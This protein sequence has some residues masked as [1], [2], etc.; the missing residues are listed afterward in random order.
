MDSNKSYRDVVLS[1]L[2][3]TPQGETSKTDT[4]RKT[5]TLRFKGRPQR[6]TIQGLPFDVIFLIFRVA[7]VSQATCLGL[8][9]RVLY[10]H[11]KT[12]HPS[13]IPLKSFSCS[14]SCSYDCEWGD[15]GR[16]WDTL[17]DRLSDSSI[18]KGYRP[19]YFLNPAEENLQ[20]RLQDWYR[21]KFVGKW[22]CHSLSY[23]SYLPSP[24]NLGSEWDK[25][26]L[27]AIKDDFKHPRHNHGRDWKSYWQSFEI[28]KENQAAFEVIMDEASWELCLTR[29][30]SEM[31]VNPE[32][33]LPTS[34]INY[35]PQGAGAMDAEIS[36]YVTPPLIKANSGDHMRDQ[37]RY[38]C[39]DQSSMNVSEAGGQVATTGYAPALPKDESPHAAKGIFAKA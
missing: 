27:D 7:G 6:G 14:G 1:N 24:Y 23:E 31:L 13:P 32:E 8:T 17:A 9:C 4:K 10:R 21:A 38:T 37:D 2:R 35:H 15:Y 20:I 36:K 39:E 34:Q 19:I 30:L 11:L 26:A 18:F 16:C 33:N 12:Y 28:V 29:P 5:L 3:P 22:K 25:K